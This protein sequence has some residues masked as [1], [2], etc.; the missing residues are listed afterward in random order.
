MCAGS[1][2]HSVVTGDERIAKQ[3]GINQ[4]LFQSKVRL[5]VEAIDEGSIVGG[6]RHNDEEHEGV[7]DI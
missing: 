4:G 5:C 6:I 1:S 3:A 7:D 2:G